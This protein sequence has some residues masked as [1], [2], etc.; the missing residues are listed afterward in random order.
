[1]A[2]VQPRERNVDIVQGSNARVV[3]PDRANAGFFDSLGYEVIVIGRSA[4]GRLPGQGIL[5]PPGDAIHTES[6]KAQL[7]TLVSSMVP[8]VWLLVS[9]LPLSVSKTFSLSSVKTSSIIDIE[10]IKAGLSQQLQKASRY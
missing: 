8:T 6:I 5:L 4:V 3:I 1:M 7:T 9:A 2:S 10:L